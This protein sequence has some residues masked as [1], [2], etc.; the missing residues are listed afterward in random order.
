M[1]RLFLAV[2]LSMLFT[3]HVAS[4]TCGDGMIDVGEQCDD[5]NTAPGDGCSPTCQSEGC[6]VTGTW[7]APG[8]PGT[9][10][11]FVITLIEGPGGAITGLYYFPGQPRSATAFTGTRN[12]GAVAVATSPPVSG[13]MNGC[14]LIEGTLIGTWMRARSTYCG[15]GII[16]ASETCD[17]G[18]LSNA[19]TC[20]VDCSP[21]YCGDGYL[22]AGEDCDDGNA[23]NGDGC[24]TTCHPNVCGNGTVESGEQC[25]DSNIVNGDGCTDRCQLQVC[26]NGIV[27]P[28]ERCDDGNVVDGDGCTATCRTEGCDVTGTWTAP[29]LPGFTPP[30]VITLVE[31]PAGVI[32]GVY[33]YPGQP[34]AATAFTGTRDGGEIAVATSPPVSGLMNGCDLIGGTLIGTWT[35]ARSTYCGDAVLQAG[36]TCDDGN[37]ENADGCHVDCS[38]GHCGDAITDPDEQCDDGNATNGDGCSTTCRTNVCGNGTIE[39]GEQCD[40]SNTIDGDGCTSRCQVQVC[41]NGVQEPGEG[42]DDGGTV[43]G[44]GCSSTCQFEGCSLTGTWGVPLFTP[45]LLTLVEAPNGSVTGVMHSGSPGSARPASGTRSGAAVTLVVNGATYSGT[46]PSCDNVALSGGFIYRIRQTYCGDGSLQA[47]ETCDDGNFA[48][49]DACD[50]TCTGSAP[51]TC[52]NGVLDAGEACDDGNA[53]DQD[54]CKHTCTPNVCGDGLVRAGVEACDDGNTVAADGCAADCL[55]IDPESIPPT[56]VGG[57]VTTVSTGTVAT[58]ADPIETTIAVPAGTTSGTVGITESSAPA[59]PASG[60]VLLG[61]VVDIAVADI[62]PPPTVA[63]PLVFTFRLDA[64]LIPPGQDE[65]TLAVTKDGVVLGNCPGLPTACVALRKR[66]ADGDV[67]LVVHTL[68]ASAWGIAASICPKTPDPTCTA[69]VAGKATLSLQSGTK[70]QLGFKWKSAAAVATS[71]LGDPLAS[72]AYTLCLY[73]RAGLATQATAPAGG[74]CRGKPCWKSTATGWTYVNPSR[75]PSGL[76]KLTLKSGAAGKANLAVKGDGASLSVPT[77][78]LAAPATVQVRSVDGACFG[79]TFGHP[80]KNDATRFSSK[81]D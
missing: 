22:D 78:P 51:A 69:A 24:S 34:A 15:D 50:V 68:T 40:D 79:A 77:L 58:P 74:L 73:D 26:G 80:K 41:G 18:D 32:T 12:A 75:T 5:G 64:S 36:E 60:F 6:D 37:L 44:D 43:S 30:F 61:T 53:S 71:Q 38:P 16:Q 72:N 3:V 65:S 56:P 17:D 29:G 76:V 28:G 62:Q 27:E 2:V 35:R 19:G 67:T 1:A 70:P 57:G 23:T 59:P 52:G 39:P 11:P 54:A 25:D 63:T 21:H 33:Y 8:L 81:S 10:P 66:E 14:D 47:G 4:A 48:S 45:T 20:N 9:T 42:C 7:T 49:G 55:S 31:A 46:M 13:V